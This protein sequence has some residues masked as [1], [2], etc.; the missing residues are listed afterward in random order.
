MRQRQF[1]VK[2]MFKHCLN[3]RTTGVSCTGGRS[4]SGDISPEIDD[5]DEVEAENSEKVSWDEF[6][7][8]LV[9]MS[10]FSRMSPDTEALNKYLHLKNRIVR[11][12]RNLTSTGKT[13]EGIIQNL[14]K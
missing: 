10:N 8:V 11:G 12:R 1:P 5:N 14:L 2:R 7:K 3:P 4:V 6:C 13:I 9:M